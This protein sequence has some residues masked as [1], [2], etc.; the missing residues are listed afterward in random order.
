MVMMVVVVVVCVRGAGAGGGGPYC[1]NLG[2][3]WIR[4]CYH[5]PSIVQASTWF[6]I[7]NIYRVAG[8]EVEN[9]FKKKVV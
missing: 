1:G 5:L 7:K 2:I 6:H 8:G 4:H 9:T 3:P